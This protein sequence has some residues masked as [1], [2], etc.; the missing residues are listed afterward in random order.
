MEIKNETLTD[1]TNSG[2][3]REIAISVEKVS[4]VY[5]L[6]N[7][8]AD[9]VLDA[10]HMTPWRKIPKHHALK[11]VDFEV[12]QGANVVI[13]GTNGSGKSTILQ[14]ITGVLHPT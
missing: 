8:P 14:I 9:R 7:K 2:E 5:K 13:I 10:L 11:E 12:Y 4:K 1:N 3:K 6:F